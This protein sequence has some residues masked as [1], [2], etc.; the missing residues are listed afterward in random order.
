MKS[1]PRRPEASRNDRI[2]TGETMTSTEIA[3]L[4][5]GEGGEGGGQGGIG[6]CAG[7]DGGDGGEGGEGGNCGGSGGCGGAGGNEGGG[8]SWLIVTPVSAQL[9]IKP[10]SELQDANQVARPCGGADESRESMP[11]LWMQ[12]LDP[13]RF[14]T[15]V[16]FG[17][18]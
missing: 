15:A 6:G 10:P 13:S 3:A 4:K 5:G 7:G 12:R 18:T 11:P 1:S 17:A 8:A 16:V 2:P 14:L 9:K